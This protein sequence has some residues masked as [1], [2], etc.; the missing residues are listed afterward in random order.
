MNVQQ[1]IYIC[2]QI[3]TDLDL[4]ALWSSKEWHERPTSHLHQC[5]Y[6]IFLARFSLEQY[7]VNIGPCISVHHLSLLHFCSTV[8]FC[9]G[10]CYGAIATTSSNRN[11]PVS[12]IF[13]GPKMQVKA[14]HFRILLT[15]QH[16]T[17]RLK[18]SIHQFH[19]GFYVTVTHSY[20]ILG[21]TQYF[22][23]SCKKTAE[24]YAHRCS[25]GFAGA[26]WLCGATSK[27]R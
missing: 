26:W 22:R 24:N 23:I 3:M 21:H 16:L 12:L 10:Q 17:I 7:Y 11:N 20:V 5:I 15:P 2:I 18:R 25:M 6:W 9:S 19:L 8:L 4:C 14:L 13:A 27:V 1:E